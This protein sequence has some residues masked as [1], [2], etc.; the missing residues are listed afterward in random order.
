MG[1]ALAQIAALGRRPSSRR[2]AASRDVRR[3]AGR[4]VQPR[5]DDVGA[6][7]RAAAVRAR[8]DGDPAGGGARDA[9]TRELSCRIYDALERERESVSA[10][11]N[12]L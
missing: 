11:H 6:A 12:F 9:L 4:R 1:E 2:P 5:G 10:L 3:R 7:H 8:G